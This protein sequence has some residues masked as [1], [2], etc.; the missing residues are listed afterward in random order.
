M[1][2]Y[3][4]P[5]AVDGHRTGSYPALSRPLNLQAAYQI[6]AARVPIKITGIGNPMPPPLPESALVTPP[7]VE[8]PLTDRLRPR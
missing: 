5:S 7:S 1:P 2:I 6:A 3:R 8:P 4:H